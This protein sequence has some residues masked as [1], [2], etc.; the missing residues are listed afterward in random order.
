MIVKMVVIHDK[1]KIGLILLRFQQKLSIIPY[2]KIGQNW[3]PGDNY[4]KYNQ[5]FWNF[6]KFSQRMLGVYF[7][8]T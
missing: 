6:Q 5:F 7:W 1:S 8:Q 3:F 4:K 2:Q